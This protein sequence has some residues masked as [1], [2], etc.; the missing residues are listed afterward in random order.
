MCPLVGLLSSA[1]LSAQATSEAVS[2]SSAQAAPPAADAEGPCDKYGFVTLFRCI[3]HDVGGL[4]Q[5]RSLVWL[6]S[7]A[8]L[9]GGS[10]LLD[11]EVRKAML[12]PEPDTSLAAG[13]YLG[14]AGL[15]FGAPLAMYAF[16]KATGK[17]EV[18]AFSVTLLRT[19]VL[20]AAVTRGFKL[21]PRARPYQE[22]VTL[23]KGSFPSGHSSAMF[24]TST[25]LQRRWGW[26]VGVPAYLLSAYVGTTRLENN[27][28]L[29]D[30]TFGAAVGVAVGFVMNLPRHGPAIAPMIAPGVAGITVDIDLGSSA[31]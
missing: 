14:H 3:L 8:V 22:T 7:G 15:H 30:V 24:A 12:D 31:E 13:E 23:T 27:H 25:V 26:K 18:A 9:A 21:I 5:G 29:S 19:H 20:N 17:D 2:A 1:T 28:Y 10:L 4:A 6:G 16:A 11:D